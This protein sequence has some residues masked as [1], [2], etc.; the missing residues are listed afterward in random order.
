MLDSLLDFLESE[1]PYKGKRD[2]NEINDLRIIS[3]SLQDNIFELSDFELEGFFSSS[4]ELSK[5]I[6]NI[7]KNPN[8]IPKY[9]RS[10]FQEGAKTQPLKPDRE[11][12]VYTSSSELVWRGGGPNR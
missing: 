2:T 3:N 4:K 10:S 5:K 7:S 12:Q 8:K 11:L 9:I 1:I 6:Q